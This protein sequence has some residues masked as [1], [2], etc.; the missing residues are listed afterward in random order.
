MIRLLAF[1][2]AAVVAS[3]PPASGQQPGPTEE[4]VIVSGG[5]EHVFQ[6]EI[7]DTP[8]EQ[9]V[10]LMYRHELPAD[11][12]MLFVNPR[13]RRQTMWMK[14]TYIPLDMLFI[15]RRGRIVH[16]AERT[17]PH[18]T[19]TISSRR[20]VKA[21]LELRGGTVDRLGIAEG[22]TVRHPAFE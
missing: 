17:V 12:G 7:A 18:S 3:V 15:D 10:G 14:N 13:E 8:T 1:L 19:E 9:A 21:T 11:G 2:L 4:V 20:P 6:V 5:A 22:D 16:I